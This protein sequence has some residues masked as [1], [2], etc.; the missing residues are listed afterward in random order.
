MTTRMMTKLT[1]VDPLGPRKHQVCDSGFMHGNDLI[2]P[3]N[4]YGNFLFYFNL[5]VNFP[6]CYWIHYSIEATLD[7]TWLTFFG[8]VYYTLVQ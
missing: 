2:K 3:T 1:I 7:F 4:H 6:L 8:Y 5:F